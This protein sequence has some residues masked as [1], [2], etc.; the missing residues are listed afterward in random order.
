M[1]FHSHSSARK[2]S[3]RFADCNPFLPV[4]IREHQRL[5]IDPI[6]TSSQLSHNNAGRG[7]CRHHKQHIFDENK[8][9]KI[10]STTSLC[11]IIYKYKT[12]NKRLEGHSSFDA[13]S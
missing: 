9:I 2:M 8:L 3:S 1:R 11:G 12:F 10:R 5:R 13:K 6:P 4:F 7:H